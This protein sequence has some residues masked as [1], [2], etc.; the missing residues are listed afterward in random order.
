VQARD[1]GKLRARVEQVR[2]ILRALRKVQPGKE[3]ISDFSNDFLDRPIQVLHGNRALGC[4]GGQLD[5]APGP[6]IGIMTSCP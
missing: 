2:R 4:G 3:M 5:C 6:G 1:A